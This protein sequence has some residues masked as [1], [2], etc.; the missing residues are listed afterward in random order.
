MTFD[1]VMD[2]LTDY[3]SGRTT[4]LMADGI[5]AKTV[6]DAAHAAVVMGAVNELRRLIQWA[7]EVDLRERTNAR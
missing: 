3:I 1:D 4:Q 2:E 6:D 5:V 7:T